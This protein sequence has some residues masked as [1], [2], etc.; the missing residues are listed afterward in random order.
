MKNFTKR[1]LAIF[2]RIPGISFFAINP[3]LSGG[4]NNNNQIP[5]GFYK[6]KQLIN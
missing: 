4:R 5:H 3:E 2:I 1:T 6:R